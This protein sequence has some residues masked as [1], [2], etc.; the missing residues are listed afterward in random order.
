MHGATDRHFEYDIGTII[1][2]VTHNH[3][4]TAQIQGLYYIL[5]VLHTRVVRG[6]LGANIQTMCIYLCKQ[7][8]R[9]RWQI[10]C[11]WALISY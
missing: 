9:F 3:K 7:A 5:Y 10:E 1:V 4:L 6:Q 8:I 2:P 11:N